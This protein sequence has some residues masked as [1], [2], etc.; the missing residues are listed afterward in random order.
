[1]GMKI[2]STIVRSGAKTFTIRQWINKMKRETSKEILFE[3]R[4]Q[5]DY[6]IEADEF[7]MLVSDPLVQKYVDGVARRLVPLELQYRF[8]KRFPTPHNKR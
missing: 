2:Q 3:I 4:S 6:G 7:E 8:I 5:E 1:M